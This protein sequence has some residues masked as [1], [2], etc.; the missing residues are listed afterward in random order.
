MQDGIYRVQL[1]AIGGI[2]SGLMIVSKCSLN[3]GD[4]GYTYQGHVQ[5]TGNNI[6]TKVHI[7]RHDPTVHSV[8]G[9]L[10]NFDLDL[11]GTLSHGGH[12]F[13][14]SGTVV[15]QPQLRI[16]ITGRKV[17]ALV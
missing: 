3:G 2:G 7:S 9:P 13:H 17:R 12:A 14:L 10:D 4:F 11:S 5:S 1:Q 8:F 15:S 6:S 16:A